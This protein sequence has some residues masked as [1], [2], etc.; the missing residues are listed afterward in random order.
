VF[1]IKKFMRSEEK[2]D[3][4]IHDK[5][6]PNDETDRFKERIKSPN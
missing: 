4:K 3:A 6:N 2:L 1:E 5:G